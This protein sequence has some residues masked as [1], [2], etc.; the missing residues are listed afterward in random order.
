MKRYRKISGAASGDYLPV[1]EAIAYFEDEYK[2]SKQQIKMEGNLTAL[3]AKI[4]GLVEYY[5]GTLQEIEAIL[6][7]LEIQETKIL[8]ETRKRYLEHYD[9]ALTDRMAEKYADADSAVIDIKL[10]IIEVAYIR[11]LFLGI[12]KSIEYSHYQLS[13]CVRLRTAGMEDATI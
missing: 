3:A 8:G 7:W 12:M 11:N 10:L 2:G 6:A 4:P 9:R 13:N 1:A 5:Y